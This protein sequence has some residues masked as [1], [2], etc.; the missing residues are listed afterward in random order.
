MNVIHIVYCQQALQ[1]LLILIIGLIITLQHKAGK[2]HLQLQA[3]QHELHVS[4]QAGQH[5][6]WHAHTKDQDLIA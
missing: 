2:R 5:S 1:H 4:Q 3:L 6:Q